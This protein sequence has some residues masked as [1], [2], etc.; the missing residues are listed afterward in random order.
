[1][2]DTDLRAAALDGTIGVTLFVLVKSLAM[3]A[4]SDVQDCV[5]L[6]ALRAYIT[7]LHTYARAYDNLLCYIPIM[8]LRYACVGVVSIRLSVSLSVHFHRCVCNI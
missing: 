4:H 1:M 6:C 3:H 8:C 5:V 2:F 7:C